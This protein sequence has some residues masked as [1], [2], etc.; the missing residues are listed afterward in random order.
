MTEVAR[1]I[2]QTYTHKDVDGSSSLDWRRLRPIST[3]L[4]SLKEWDESL[5]KALSKFTK[6]LHWQI[7]E[8]DV[9]EEWVS[10]GGKVRSDSFSALLRPRADWVRPRSSSFAD[11]LRRRRRTSSR[12]KRFPCSNRAH[13]QSL[14]LSQCPAYLDT[15]SVSISRRRSYDCTLS[16]VGGR[17]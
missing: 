12:C 9:Q 1:I 7:L 5:Q 4:D 14:T 6:V 2:N 3:M 11:M 10:K 17:E 15:R 16:V 13:L 8:G